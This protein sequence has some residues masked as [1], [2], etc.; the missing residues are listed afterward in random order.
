MTDEPESTNS[1]MKRALAMEPVLKPPKGYPGRK[2]PM[3]PEEKLEVEFLLWERRVR[4]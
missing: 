1:M 2:E 4:K 3:T